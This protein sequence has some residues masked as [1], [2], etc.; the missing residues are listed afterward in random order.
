MPSGNL[1]WLLFW[2]G[3]GADA[4][5]WVCF[6]W[7]ARSNSLLISRTKSGLI[8]VIS[9]WAWAVPFYVTLAVSL[10]SPAWLRWASFELPGWLQTCGAVTVSLTPFFCWWVLRSLGNNFADAFAAVFRQRLVTR[11]PYR[12]VRH[13]LYALECVFLLTISLATA[14]WVLLG[15]A[16]SGIPIICLVVIP[17]EEQF[18]QERFGKAYI[19]YRKR[20]GVLLPR[21]LIQR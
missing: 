21:L 9:T 12:Y 17:H 2:A 7:K 8:P 19:E 5:L 4:A 13:P 11:G 16:C 3:V 6:H 15:F 18:L 10:L 14:N 1:N 20:T